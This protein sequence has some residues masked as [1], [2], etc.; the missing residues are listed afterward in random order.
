MRNNY[1]DQFS[2]P[3]TI[4][5]GT[6]YR[7]FNKGEVSLRPV[8]DK[9]GT[10]SFQRLPWWD[11][12]R[13][14]YLML[15]IYTGSTIPS[16]FM[17]EDE[18]T[19]VL[20]IVDGQQRTCAIVE[21]M[22]DS[23]KI[24]QNSILEKDFEVV[25]DELADKYFSELDSETQRKIKDY[26]LRTEYLHPPRSN[27]KADLVEFSQR[28]RTS[29]HRLN[30]TSMTMSKTE[31]WNST[32]R[33]DIIDLAYRIQAALGFKSPSE[34]ETSINLKD[35]QANYW[36]A[37]AG[38]VSKT[39]ILRMQDIDLVLQ[40]LHMLDSDGQPQHKEEGLQEFCRNGVELPAGRADE[41]FNAFMEVVG[42]LQKIDATMPLASV[43]YRKRHDFY[44]LFCAVTYMLGKGTISPRD[45]LDKAC[46]KLDAFN[47]AL[48]SYKDS[49]LGTARKTRAFPAWDTLEIT[50]TMRGRVKKYHESKL[51]DWS[52]LEHRT[53]RRD[54]L[55]LVGF[56]VKPS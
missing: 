1:A 28:V 4:T 15:S 54:T 36:F 17:Y 21:Y 3:A 50:E 32:F 44:S 49:S 8:L 30:V 11:K 29:F 2:F 14:C 5:V 51:R 33:G 56:G 53:L 52:V 41:L 35:A 39:D 46:A 34:Q 22:N 18:D 38:I 23:F 55:M 9:G 47:V 26:T 12:A 6:L 24:T 16:L 7:R 48:V 45:D 25:P 10:H 20:G 37:T 42:V 19:D 13:K 31:I 40:L 27:R 43:D